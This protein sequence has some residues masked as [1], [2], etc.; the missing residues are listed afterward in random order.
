M[1]RSILLAMRMHHG[2]PHASIYRDAACMS[3]YSSSKGRGPKSICPNVAVVQTGDVFRDGCGM[4]PLSFVSSMFISS[5]SFSMR[6]TAT[7]VR[8]GTTSMYFV[9]D[10]ALFFFVPRFATIGLFLAT[11]P[12]GVGAFLNV[13]EG[14][15]RIH[16]QMRPNEQGFKVGRCA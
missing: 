11:T 10:Q 5:L 4:V 7:V 16:Y 6:A 15:H 12:A 8:V 14:P 13:V 2:L 1:K 9:V 3:H